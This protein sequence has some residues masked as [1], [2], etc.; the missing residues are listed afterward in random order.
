MATFLQLCQQVG[1]DSGLLANNGPS[2]VVSQTA[3]ARKVVNWVIQ[4]WRTIQLSQDHWRWMR[5]EF[6]F[7]SLTPNTARYTATALSITDWARWVTEIDTLT[8]YLT[9]TGVSDEGELRWMGWHDYRRSYERGTQV[10]ARPVYAAISPADELCFGAKPDLA[11]TVRG[12]YY[13]TP[14]ILALDAD[15]PECPTMYHD[16]IA[17]KAMELAQG[18]EVDF[19]SVGFSVAQR[20]ELESHM[21]RTQLPLISTARPLA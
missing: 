12:E 15:V 8:L 10:A 21:R 11:Y 7:A 3:D 9:A 13:A 6:S 16:L 18:H 20:L 14:Q 19:P 17:W 2:T 4:A 1:R 5:K